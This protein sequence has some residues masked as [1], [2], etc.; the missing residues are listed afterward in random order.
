MAE[1]RRLKRPATLIPLI[2]VIFLV[3]W[4]A[5]VI[6]SI[7]NEEPDGEPTLNE[8]SSAV[9]RAL[10][11]GDAGAFGRLVDSDSS[12]DD[13]AANYVERLD[14][15]R[16]QG[17]RTTVLRREKD[18]A[19]TV[20]AN[21]DGGGVVCSTWSAIRSEGRWVLD[22]APALSQDGGCGAAGGDNSR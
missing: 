8:L 4:M 22:A 20:V 21:V 14:R 15:T 6:V 16:P 9:E 7:L 2:G 19:I 18:P 12:G 1:K 10:K 3:G 17:I 11:D 5:T 13:Y